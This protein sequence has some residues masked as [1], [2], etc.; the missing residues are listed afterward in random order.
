MTPFS[1]PIAPT[2]GAGGAR[3][4]KG[5]Q[6]LCGPC[7]HCGA[8]SS[9]QWRKGP[10]GKPILCNA[11]GIRFLRTRSLGKVTPKKRRSPVGVGAGGAAAG[12]RLKMEDEDSDGDE[13][14]TSSGAR[15]WGRGAGARSGRAACLRGRD[16]GARLWACP[17]R[18][19]SKP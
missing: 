13:G 9:P 19:H 8:S 6:E 2:P 7:C 3:R 18:A 4:G 17:L 15:R 11:C 1:L 12:K 14:R 10:K 5:K 16:A